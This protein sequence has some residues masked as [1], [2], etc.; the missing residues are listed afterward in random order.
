VAIG[1]NNTTG[2]F[3]GQKFTLDVAEVKPDCITASSLFLNRAWVT[4]ISR[5]V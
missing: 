1:D 2:A 5:T 3:L 4:R